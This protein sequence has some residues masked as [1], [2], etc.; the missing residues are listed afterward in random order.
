ML[1]PESDKDVE[2]SLFQRANGYWHEETKVHFDQDGNPSEHKVRKYYPPDSTAMIFWLKNRK[3]KE[4]RDRQEIEHS[5][6]VDLASVIL[7]RRKK[8]K[9]GSDA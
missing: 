7:E 4:W 1:L 2:R 9:G 5:G 6:S 3:R 8:A